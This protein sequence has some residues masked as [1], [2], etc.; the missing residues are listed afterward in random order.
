VIAALA[1]IHGTS[2]FVITWAWTIAMLIGAG[3]ALANVIDAVEDLAAV[4]RLAVAGEAIRGGPRWWLAVGTVA[5]SIMIGATLVAFGVVGLL[6]ISAGERD[7]GNAA[8]WI[9]FLGGFTVACVPPVTKYTRRRVK[10]RLPIEG[11]RQP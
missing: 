3:V 4:R 9:L 1:K 7:A 8:V 2:R 6:A 5:A 10:E 11:R